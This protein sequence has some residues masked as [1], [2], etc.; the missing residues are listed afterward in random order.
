MVGPKIFVGEK[1]K[2]DEISVR[3]KPGKCEI[4]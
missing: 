1:K 3:L 2:K 4:M